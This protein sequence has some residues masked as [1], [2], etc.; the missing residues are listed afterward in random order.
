M[1]FT[2]SGG[3]MAVRE[4]R[5]DC[6]YCGTKEILGRH[7]VCTSCA[8]SRPEG[9]KFYLAD[10]AAEVSETKQLKEAQLG[11][12]WVCQYCASSNRADRTSCQHCG[13]AREESSPQQQVQNFK[14]G[15]APRS[16]DM[17]LEAM[18][19][20]MTQPAKPA[21]LR[22]N[23]AVLGIGGLVGL[24]FLCI[25]LCGG[26]FLFSEKEV[27]VTVAE[28]R[29]QRTIQVEAYRTVVE[30]DWSVPAGGRT[31]SQREA[32]HHYDSVLV[33]YETQQREV[34]EQVQTGSRTYVCGQRDL[35]N[36]YFEDVECSEPIY[37]TQYRTETEQVPIY[38]QVPVYQTEYSYEIEK[39]VVDRTE[40]AAG[41]ER[42][43]NWPAV[44]LAENERE[45][46]RTE[47]YQV[48][49]VDEEGKAY[50]MTFTEGEWLA[51][52]RGGRY[53]LKVTRLGEPV[54]VVE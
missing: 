47:A 2:H 29:W 36:G 12:D 9:T 13:A 7:T 1:A 14:A 49:F 39:W 16:G 15:E 41:T 11:A 34:S 28:I 45:G 20:P 53:Q 24:L 6:Q 52:E 46:Q 38:E 48:V 33:G 4:G 18:A 54:E 23:R 17:D 26:Y 30:E 37:E 27:D 42:Q 51:F 3:C 44:T 50:E 21:G 8:K 22:W 32:I 40:E 19:R 10:E 35:G 25:C 5:W 31:I 43:T